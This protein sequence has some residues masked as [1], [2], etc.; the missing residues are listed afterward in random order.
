MTLCP[1][2]AVTFSLA[3]LLAT[4]FGAAADGRGSKPMLF[5]PEPRNDTAYCIDGGGN[6][7]PCSTL[8]PVSYYGHR[9]VSNPLIW[10]VYW[11]GGVNA[12]T[13]AQLPGFYD[14]VVNSPLFDWMVE[15]NTNFSGANGT[16]QRMG[17]GVYGGAY[18]ITPTINTSRNVTD[19]DISA[20]LQS[21][22]DNGQLPQ[23]DN[24]SIFMVYFPPLYNITMS[25][26][27]AS[28]V[29]F[30]AYHGTSLYHGQD[31]FYG[32][33]PDIAEGSP[34]NGVCGGNATTFQNLCSASS[35]EMIETVTD[36]EVGL[37]DLFHLSSSYAWDS[38]ASGSLGAGN[39]VGDMC[40]QFPGTI[41]SLS[42]GTQYTIQQQYSQN[43]K[44]CQTSY[45]FA[46]DYQFY[47]NP[48]L[49]I[50]SPGT[51]GSVPVTQNIIDGNVPAHP[52][53][54]TGGLAGV[55]AALDK[56]TLSGNDSTD[57]RFTVPGNAVL[58][59][60]AVYTLT[61]TDPTNASYISTRT[62]TVMLRVEPAP[63]ALSLTGITDGQKVT[64][65]VTLHGSAS[66]AAN[67]SIY[68]TGIYIDYALVASGTPSGGAS[69]STFAWNT[70]ALAG[71]SSHSVIL[72]AEDT[73]GAHAQLNYSV[74]IQ[75]LPK[76]QIVSPGAGT[77]TGLV[78]LTATGT[79]AT[80]GSIAHLAVG[81]D[82][83]QVAT[84]TTSPVTDS[85]NTTLVANGAHLLTA[86][87][88][89]TDGASANATPFTVTVANPPAITLSPTAITVTGVVLLQATATPSHGGTISTISL[90][91]DGAQ[92]ASG[93]ASPLAFQWDTSTLRSGSTHT[94]VGTVTDTDGLFATGMTGL[95]LLAGPTVSFTS[96]SANATIS[97][98]TSISA[99]ATVPPGTT[100][101][102]F[103][104][105]IDGTTIKSGTAGT[106]ADTFDTR[107]LVNGAHAI[108]A[109]ATDADSGTATS[110]LSVNVL[111]IAPANNFSIRVDPVASVLFIGGAPLVL[112]VT[113]TYL[114]GHEAV[115]LSVT[116]L[117]P[118]VTYAFSSP[119]VQSGAS[120][121]LTLTAPKG[122]A[123]SPST[124]FAI[125][126]TSASVPHGH[127]VTASLTVEASPASGC[128]TFAGWEFGALFGLVALMRRR[129]LALH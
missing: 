72:F 53:S 95:T 68:Y 127:N 100:L 40:N 124:A 54:I 109:T 69:V 20:E 129:K 123:A 18:T 111:N 34:C 70:S 42:D 51:T 6:Y 62:A 80:G 104:L 78:T 126:G 26:G 63:T 5:H 117:P 9:I 7:V 73:D 2:R 102:S 37:Y 60:Q 39:E 118:G 55:T 21:Q 52:I 50:L 74:T 45:Y 82:A 106:L 32:V 10:V 122:T 44:Q 98:S 4:S 115:A 35:H 83:V 17:R 101:Q 86:T 19:G 58:N 31:L 105:A 125:I 33:F 119:T 22:M 28:C 89:D 16:N 25:S 121:K 99:T 71:G 75:A 79:A 76:V 47:V 128:T 13:K 112:D 77:V 120:A 36:A 30:C 38:K 61:A 15:Y 93:A 57:L 97:G 49:L 81:I 91:I 1:L 12:T 48:T 114:N 56:T 96:P 103:V 41:E 107:T 66:P 59:S 88:T 43:T 67:R 108:T 94:I 87:I 110:T 23:P 65:T 113:T 3:M 11:T 84:A 27:D 92:V 24:N 46:P 14:T 8:A 29:K 85:W 64:G 90:T 116:G